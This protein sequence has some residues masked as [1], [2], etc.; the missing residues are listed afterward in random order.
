MRRPGGPPADWFVYGTLMDSEVRTR[1]LGHPVRGGRLRAAVVEGWRRVTVDGAWYP[2]L[3]RAPGGRVEGLLMS[4][5]TAAEEAHLVR[6]EGS[7][8]EI[9]PVT[10]HVTGRNRV[11]RMFV[12]R[13]G[14][15]VSDDEWTLESWRRRH[16]RDFLRLAGRWTE[17]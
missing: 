15:A 4:G 7:E 8:Y 9:A 5:V 6:F 14:V 3:V 12:T 13:P 10:V 1:V 17:A 16:R 11:A 2:T